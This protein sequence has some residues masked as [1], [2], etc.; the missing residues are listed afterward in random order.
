MIRYPRRVI[1]ASLVAVVILAICVGTAV[2]V[3]QSLTG[4][5]PLIPFGTLASFG[6]KLR[7][8]GAVMISAGAVSAALGLILLACALLPGQPDT[9][10]LTAGEGPAADDTGGDDW[11]V[12]AAAGVSRSGLRTALRVT[13]TGTDGV[14]SAR[15]RVRRRRVK[16]RIRTEL[17]DTGAV[18]AS[19]QAALDHR[20]GQTGLARPPKLRISVKRTGKKY[21]E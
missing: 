19:V 13:V 20:L 1:P 11:Q 10:P 8:D 16:T 15:L 5:P 12:P 3:I 7:L 9:L 6:R 14:T 4:H 17:Q 2:S 21:P 18:R